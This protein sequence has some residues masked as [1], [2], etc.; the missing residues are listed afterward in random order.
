MKSER[1]T[2]LV[3]PFLRKLP[4]RADWGCC[5][6]WYLRATVPNTL[7]RFYVGC[8]EFLCLGAIAFNSEL[9]CYQVSNSV[10][11][12]SSNVNLT[13]TGAALCGQIDGG[14]CTTTKID[15][16][17]FYNRKLSI[18]ELVLND[19]GG[20]GNNPSTTENLFAWYQVEKFETLDFSALQDN[21]DLRLGI[22]DMSGKNNH[23]QPFNLDTNVTSSTYVLKPF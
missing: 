7:F 13:I 2:S 8:D 11:P 17:R 9:L 20:T 16:M 4:P 10:I 5:T 18:D 3:N 19:N 22:R 12:I 1:H 23:A 6:K 14:N 15:E 21:S